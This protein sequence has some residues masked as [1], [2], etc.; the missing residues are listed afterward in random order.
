[1][2]MLNRESSEEQKERKNEPQEIINAGGIRPGNFN[3]PG[4]LVISSDPYLHQYHKWVKGF[5]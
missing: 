1:M 2:D 4:D 3:E 5:R